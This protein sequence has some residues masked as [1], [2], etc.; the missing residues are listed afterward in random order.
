MASGYMS[1]AKGEIKPAPLIDFGADD[2]SGGLFSSLRDMSRY[3]AAQL[4]AYPPRNEPE[5]GALRRS[6][7]REAHS[8][9]LASLFR[10]VLADTSKKG[11]SLVDAVADSY[12]FG[13]VARRSCAFDDLV[14]HNGGLPGFSSDIRFLKDRGV[15]VIAL[16]NLLPAEAAAIS[17]RVVRALARSG[18]LSKR[19]L[20]PPPQ[21]DPLM[22]KLLAVYNEWDEGV[23]KS[24]LTAR[25]PPMAAIE[26][27]ELAGYKELHGVCKGYKF[28]ESSSPR[29]ATFSL[30]CERGPLEMRLMTSPSDGLLTGFVGTTRGLPVPKELRPVAEKVTGLIRK[31]DAAIF[32]RYFAKAKKTRDAAATEFEALRLQHG[33]CTVHSSTLTSDER[34]IDLECERGGDLDLTLEIDK[35]DPNQVLTYA[36]STK[37]GVCP[38]R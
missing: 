14:W 32:S 25:R 19:T 28:A 4:A 24:I 27:E 17:V 35:K 2:P 12:G 33:I 38:M 10:V 7:L 23:Y 21:F 16:V 30:E 37:E 3:V 22:K 5:D 13:W 29:S 20:P 9:G 31:W 15:G 6:T 36:L 26:K 18:G 34:T 1:F 11:E 8:S